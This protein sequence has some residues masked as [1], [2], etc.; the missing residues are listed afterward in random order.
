MLIAQERY[1]LYGL[2]PEDKGVPLK[3]EAIEHRIRSFTRN[4]FQVRAARIEAE[5]KGGVLLGAPSF[6]KPGDTVQVSCSVINDGL[7]VVACIEDGIIRLD[8]E[9][10]DEPMNRVTLV[11]YPPDVVAGAVGILEY[12][13]VMPRSKAAIASETISRHAV[14]YRVPS[15]AESLAGYPHEVTAFLRPYMRACF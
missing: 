9:L 1:P 2:D 6:F 15:A 13:R 7:Y 4:R 11:R 3:L 10:A 5:S 12:E 8:R 14:S